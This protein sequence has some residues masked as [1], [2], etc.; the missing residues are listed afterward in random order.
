MV[1]STKRISEKREKSAVVALEL[2]AQF[3]NDTTT[4]QNAMMS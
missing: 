2:H 3:D 1:E 4:V